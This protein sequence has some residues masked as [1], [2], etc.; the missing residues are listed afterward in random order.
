VNRD[1]RNSAGDVSRRR[2][3]VE[4]LAVLAEAVV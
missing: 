2:Q 3:Q 4:N 1:G